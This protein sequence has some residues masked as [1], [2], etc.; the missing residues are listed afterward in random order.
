MNLTGSG[1]HRN[2][3]TATMPNREALQKEYET[4]TLVLDRVRDIVASENQI[5]LGDLFTASTLTELHK[6]LF[7]GVFEH[8]GVLRSGAIHVGFHV[9]AASDVE[10]IQTWMQEYEKDCL[11]RLKMVINGASESLVLGYAFWKLTYI[12]PF[13]DGNGRVALLQNMLI[14]KALGL[15]AT[16][17]YR[18]DVEAD[19]YKFKHAL[20]DWDGG[21]ATPFIQ[22]VTDLFAD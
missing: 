7:E 18:K 2:N 13:E 20:R 14:Q 12:A 9:P 11:K 17:L 19:Y 8:A 4:R 6:Q 21:N 3:G 5:A 1:H 10:S 22:R 16:P 15:P